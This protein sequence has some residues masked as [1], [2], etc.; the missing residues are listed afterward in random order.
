MNERDRF[1]GIV[2][3]LNEAMLDDARWPGTSALI[4]EAFRTKG[5]VLTFGGEIPTGTIEIFFTKCYYRG[6]DRSAW[7]QDYFRHYH[8]EDE[9][10]PRLRAL[11][12]SKIVPVADLFSEEERKTSRM[13]NEALVRRHGQKGLTMRLDGP[14]GSRIVWGIADPIDASGWSSAQIEMIARVL[15]HLRQYVRV[16]SALAEAGAL[17]ASTTELLDNARVGVIQ[18]DRRGRIV[19]A[20]DSARELLRRNDGLSDQSGVLHAAAP[21]DNDRLQ[22]LLA[23]A[24]PRFGEQGASGSMMVRRPS[25]LARL[26]LH[27]NPVAN[28]EVDYRSRQV[29]AALVLIVDPVKRARIDP[30][31]VEAVL[32]LTPVETQI[33]VLLAEGRTARQIAAATGRGYS[34]VRTH[35]KHIFAKLGVSRQLEV[36]QL[37]LALSSL[38]VSR[39]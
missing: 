35:L 39:D 34:T 17:G 21:E 32:G 9:H 11:P 15:P 2:D 24:M 38:P 28:R 14:G 20:N 4:D 30:G 7:L 36:A 16:R 18:L 6:V 37:V 31:V 19:D 5:N 23:Q 13:Y 3:S 10:L 26:A 8:R 22:A 33:A 1:E 12:D 29:V 25:L 27:V